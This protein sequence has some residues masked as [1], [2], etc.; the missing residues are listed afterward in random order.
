MRKILLFG[1]ALILLMIL[2]VS[3]RA[4][5][6]MEPEYIDDPTVYDLREGEEIPDEEMPEQ[7]IL[8]DE[9]EEIESTKVTYKAKVLKVEEVSCPDEVDEKSCLSIEYELLNGEKKGE[10]L[11]SEEIDTRLDVLVK[12]WELEEGSKVVVTEFIYGDQSNFQ[13]TEIYRANSLLWFLLIYIVF[14]LIIGR[15]Q[16]LGSLV[17]LGISILVLLKIV[18]PMTLSGWDPIL[19]SIFGGLCVLL[20]SIYLSHGFNKKTTIALVGTI[21]GL[22]VTGI[23][24]AIAI[25]AANLTGFGSEESLYLV[26]NDK[27]VLD[28]GGILLASIIIGGIGL[29]DDVTV[30]QVAVI[31]EIY[32]ENKNIDTMKLYSKAMNVG[33]DHIASMVNTLF[34][35]YAAA[36]LPLVMILVDQNANL[37]DLANMEIFAEEIIRTLVASTGL[38]LTVPITTL[39]GASY[40]TKKQRPI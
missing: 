29:I 13:I 7:A 18:I 33:R 34:L 39:I 4:E 35:A 32:L 17:G 19:L 37:V 30:G 27:E 22:I 26:T 21:L 38:V 6:P 1:T 3:V 23:L 2:V 20:P 28:L 9:Y 14:V 16:G 31:R 36:S 40:Y 11:T 24:A 25:N 10:V 5:A 15:L 12:A 8:E